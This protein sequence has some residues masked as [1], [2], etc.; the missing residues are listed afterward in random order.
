M[1]EHTHQNNPYN[2]K[3][4]IRDRGFSIGNI[5]DWW[6]SSR[7]P[8]TEAIPPGKRRERNI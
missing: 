5:G 1:D 3:S 4:D 7:I 2:I 6:T 8:T